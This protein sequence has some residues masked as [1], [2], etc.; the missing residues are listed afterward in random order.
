MLMWATP[1]V[2]AASLLAGPLRCLCKTYSTATGVGDA[3]GSQ[4]EKNA[5]FEQW[6]RQVT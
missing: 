5:R 4:H 3:L 1:M 6:I 2:L